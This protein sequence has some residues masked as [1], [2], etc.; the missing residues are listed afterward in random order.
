M[1]EIFEKSV[2]IL[3]EDGPTTLVNRA[4]Q[5]GYDT[6][7]RTL[8]PKQVVTYNGVLVRA[9]RLGD[10]L[11][12]WHTR[13]ISG[14]ESTLVKGIRQYVE[15]GDTVVVVGGGWG[16]STVEAAKQAGAEGRV[17]TFEG[18]A[19]TV[20]NVEDTV[21]LND[22]DNRVSVRYAI[23]AQA[24]SL[25]GEGNDAQVLSPTE[26]P[27]CDVLVL[28]CEGAEIN[29]L[30]EME[31]RPRA[32]I[33][34]THGMFDAPEATVRDRLN[35]AGY[36]TVESRV[37]E[38]RLRKVCEENGIHVLFSLRCENAPNEKHPN[39]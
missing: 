23:I 11:V 16:V 21:A 13:D 12:P 27:D 22:V 36:E 31:I 2:R 33:V 24:I 34:E 8:L 18:G 30:K 3:R 7:I 28:D 19:K 17:I 29:I 25:R 6:W 38:E 9:S 4:V 10:S 15:P 20:E 35:D 37:A 5:F 26:L 32:V 14:Y 39:A 1:A